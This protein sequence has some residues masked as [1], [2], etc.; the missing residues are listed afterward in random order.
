MHAKVVESSAKNNNIQYALK[1]LSLS[2][3]K[4]KQ[5]QKIKSTCEK[6]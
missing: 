4:Q 6:M 5:I 2:G 3:K 1:Y